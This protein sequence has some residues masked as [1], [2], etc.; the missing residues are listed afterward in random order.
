MEYIVALQDFKNAI[1]AVGGLLI[2][3][4]FYCIKLEID[5]FFNGLNKEIQEWKK[6]LEN[7]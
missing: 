6:E 5:K 3:L 4:F 1:A 7:E 2:G